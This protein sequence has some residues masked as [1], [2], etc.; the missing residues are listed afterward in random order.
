MSEKPILF[1]DLK[2][3]QLKKLLHLRGKSVGGNKGFLQDRLKQVLIDEGI[4]EYESYDFRMELSSQTATSSVAAVEA[5]PTVAK[6]AK[7]R[8]RIGN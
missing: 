6:P 5:T 2:I 3:P 7:G 8:K 1:R 4:Q